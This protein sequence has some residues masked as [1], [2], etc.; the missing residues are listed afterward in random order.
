MKILYYLYTKHKKRVA[1]IIQLCLGV[2]LGRILILKS[3]NTGLQNLIAGEQQAMSTMLWAIIGLLSLSIIQP[4]FY[5]KSTR[6][7]EDFILSYRLRVGKKIRNTSL[8]AIEKIGEYPLFSGIVHQL[9]ILSQSTHILIMFSQA[10]CEWLFVTLYVAIYVSFPVAVL[11]LFG[12]LLLGLTI[13]LMNPRIKELT[14]KMKK[15]NGAYAQAMKDLLFGFKEL[16]VNYKKQEDLQQTQAVYLK[17]IH[18][19][20]PEYMSL[21]ENIQYYTRIANYSLLG[22]LVFMFPFILKLPL[23][24]AVQ[25]AVAILFLGMPLIRIAVHWGRLPFLDS[26]LEDALRIEKNLDQQVQ[27]YISEPSRAVKPLQF[28]HSL[29]IKALKFAYAS[30]D[31]QAGYQLGPIDLTIAKGE[32]LFI[33]GGN[34]SGKST[35]L[36]VLTGLYEATG[37]DI[38]VDEQAVIAENIGE[39]RELFAAIFT[40][41]H[42]PNRLLG[43]KEVNKKKVKHLLSIFGL[44]GKTGIEGDRLTNIDLSTGQK[45]RLAM[46]QA[47]LENKAIY[48]FDEVAADQDPEHRKLFYEFILPDIKAAGKTVL[49][50]SHDDH[51]FHVADRVLEM[52]KGVLVP[53]QMKK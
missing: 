46:L 44:K 29:T 23:Q 27:L 25:L 21:T 26:V 49:V 1:V 52:K 6:F 9:G 7:L 33:V 43:V 17:E 37:G 47:F 41:F 51:Y 2:A 50:V 14:A 35:I 28:D 8:Q 13:S 34:G 36:K 38:F 18:E 10:V 11:V 32:V 39:Y 15:I 12:V 16:K 19:I 4:V 40:D 3:V 42:L 48:I 53:Y 5:K 24:Q 22:A 30:T 45:K 31:D 20:L